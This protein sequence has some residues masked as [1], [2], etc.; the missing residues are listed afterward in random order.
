[1]SAVFDPAGLDEEAFLAGPERHAHWDGEEELITVDPVFGRPFA[2]IWDDALRE[3][4]DALTPAPGTG[5]TPALADARYRFLGVPA[6]VLLLDGADNPVGGYLGC[7]LAIEPAHRGRGLG[8]EIVL[9]YAMRH[10]RIPVWTHGIAAYSPAGEAAHRAAHRL[11]RR[12]DL[13]ARKRAALLA[14]EPAA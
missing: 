11:A 9:E 4:P 3:E 7:D 2:T 1:M 14:A 5:R 8:A 13:F 6:G 12:R 10:G